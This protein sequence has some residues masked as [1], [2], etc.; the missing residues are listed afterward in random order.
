MKMTCDGLRDCTVC[1]WKVCCGKLELWQIDGL[2][3]T[4][5]FVFYI[6]KGHGSRERMS[7]W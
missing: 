2:L 5:V 4:M 7:F 1:T 6:R 3:E